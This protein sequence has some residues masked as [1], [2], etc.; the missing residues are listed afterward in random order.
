MAKLKDKIG[1]CCTPQTVPNVGGYCTPWKQTRVK[2]KQKVDHCILEGHIE[3]Y[4]SM[5]EKDN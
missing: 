5:K 4:M 1:D 2:T 3:M